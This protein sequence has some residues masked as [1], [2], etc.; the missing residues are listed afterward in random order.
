MGLMSS[1]ARLAPRSLEG[2]MIALLALALLALFASLVVIELREHDSAIETASAGAP[3]RRLRNLFDT[4]NGVAEHSVPGVLEIAS[5]CHA[6][7]TVTAQP[8][9]HDQATSR[10]AQL[11]ARIASQFSLDSHRLSIGQAR[12]WR[13][14]FSYRECPHAQLDLPVDAVVVSLRLDSGRWLNAE[15]HAHEWHWR[16]KLAWML[17]ASAVFV[18][19]GGIAIFFMRRLSR[20][21][22]RLTDAAQ[23][24]GA[25]LQ[26]APLAES[27][28]PDLKRAIRAFNQMQQQ[29]ADEV[30]RR[31]NTLAAISHDVRTPLTALRIKAELIDDA[32]L[33]RDMIA[34]VNRMEKITAAALEFLKGE[35]HAEPMRQVDL[36]E[37]LESECQEFAELGRPV[38]FA[39]VYGI[40]CKC[41]PDALARAVRN[42]IDNAIK[43]GG[44]ARVESRADGEFVAILV[45]DTGPGIPAELE[46][47][48][49]RPFERLSKARSDS[50]GGF[51][52]GLA[53]AKAIATGHG[54]ELT[55]EANRPSGL[56][57][58]IRVPAGRD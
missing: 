14:D 12:L 36:S 13:D 32:E 44:D 11:R 34:S 51:G 17:R 20:P 23:S 27:G 15:I 50:G 8:F 37:L 1:L 16:E 19:V 29:V 47:L 25:G 54:G 2:Q 9:V 58:T 24:F 40:H 4:L 56:I 5:S 38:S 49:L 10:V 46:E 39:G 6:G 18:F 48:A 22:N 26:V 41:R 33:R 30:A 35:A 42:L 31:A 53:V 55:L 21:L 45:S 52:L 43:Y 57:A 28:P 7:Y 3:L